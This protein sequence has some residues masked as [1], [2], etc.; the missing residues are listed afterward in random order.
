[1]LLRNAVRTRLLSTPTGTALDAHNPFSCN[2][3][4]ANSFLAIF[5]A[6]FLHR[7]AAKP[8]IPK[9]LQIQSVIFFDLDQLQKQRKKENEHEALLGGKS[10]CE[11]SCGG[12]RVR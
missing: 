2:I 11:N 9:D 8:C 12:P 1:M 3:L 7:R 5:Y 10:R 4:R 6:D